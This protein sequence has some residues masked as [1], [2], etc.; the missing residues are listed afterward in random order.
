[1][2]NG[3]RLP[4]SSVRPRLLDEVSLQTELT[5]EEV[6]FIDDKRTPAVGTGVAKSC[7]LCSVGVKRTPA[8]DQAT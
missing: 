1:M 4:V 2:Q 5:Y 7:G 8:V 3:L 6:P